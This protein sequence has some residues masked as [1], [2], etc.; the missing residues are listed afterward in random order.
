MTFNSEAITSLM[1]K[2]YMNKDICALS[3]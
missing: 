2:Y 3:R 1:Y